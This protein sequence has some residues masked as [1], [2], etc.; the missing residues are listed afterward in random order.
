[1]TITKGQTVPP[2]DKVAFSLKTGETSA[3]VHT[4]YGWHIIQALSAVKPTK[5]TPLKAVQDSIRQQLLQTKKT[6]TMTKWFNDVKKSF[7]K[8]ISYQTG[9]APPSTTTA[10]T[11][12]QPT[13]TG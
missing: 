11:T 4:T 9:Y 12:T 3:P 13:T 2:F 1:L 7:D 10:A 6:D 8:N 5:Q